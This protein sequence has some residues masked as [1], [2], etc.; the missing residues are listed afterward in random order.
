MILIVDSNIILAGL[1]KEGKTRE[2][3]IYSPFKLYAPE[4]LTE[5]IIKYKQYVLD[6][7]GLSSE[8]F[9][10]LFEILT[11]DLTIVSKEDYLDL[12]IEAEKIIGA[13]DKK[14]IPFIALALAIPNS[15][16]WTNDNDFLKQNKIKIYRT[17]DLLRDSNLLG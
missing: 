14:D 13:T 9:D 4:S 6:K 8:D 16:I 5:E 11:E 12:F 3:L 2:L 1:L 15:G 10:T 17:E 7:S